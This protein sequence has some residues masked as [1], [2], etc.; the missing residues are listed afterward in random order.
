MKNK[1]FTLVELLVV[2]SVI[3]LL[4]SIVF[5][6]LNGAKKKARDI[7]RVANLKM[8]CTA[9]EAYYIENGHYPYVGCSHDGE[10]FDSHCGVY[11]DAKLDNDE[12][13]DVLQPFLVPGTLNPFVPN[14][15]DAREPSTHW[16]YFYDNYYDSVTPANT[17]ETSECNDQAF[18]LL[19]SLETENVPFDWEPAWGEWEDRGWWRACKG[20]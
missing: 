20:Y 19:G 13:F 9:L 1:G 14:D 12:I 6:S 16:S 11:R 5:I 4:A 15:P 8:I 18:Q 3:G 2:I 7:R 17:P 10:S